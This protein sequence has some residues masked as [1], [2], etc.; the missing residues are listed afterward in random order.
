MKKKL[1]A[2]IITLV[3]LMVQ[4]II[5][6]GL[7]QVY[8]GETSNGPTM[9]SN[10]ATSTGI[11]S[12]YTTDRYIVKYKEN[13]GDK[14]Q[15]GR[16]NLKK[17]LE[18]KIKQSKKV[19]SKKNYD[20]ITLKTK[21]KP[22][23]FINQM[24]KDNED[25]EYIQP[26]YE[27]SLSS[28]DANF[29][30]QWGVNNGQSV[31]DAVYGEKHIDANVVPAWEISR[32]EG[33][34]VAV[35]DTGVDISHEDLSGNVW[36]NAKEIAGNGI[37]DDGNGYIDDVNG[38]N[39]FDDNNKV[40]NQATVNED[41]HGTHVSGIIA[42]VKDN[43]KGIA[44]VAPK[45]KIM[46]LKV[47][48]NGT[49]YTSD[50][51]E[52][53]EYAES[54][55][56]KIV[57]CS[58]GTAKD[59]LALKETIQQSKM[60]FVCA[61]G[62]SAANID[63]SPV[64]PASY[65]LNNVI[66]VASI[67]KS[68]KLT[69]A[70]NY[71][72]SST[73][74]AAPGEDIY[75]TLP[76][77]TYGSRSGTSLAAG[78][79][80]GEAALIVSRYGNLTAQEVKQRI[81]SSSDRL[82][83]LVGKV[84]RGNKINVN[85]AL[86]GLSSEQVMNIGESGGQQ[87]GSQNVDGYSTFYSTPQT[88]SGTIF[89]V[90]AGATNG[91]LNM[92]LSGNTIT[93]LRPFS[94]TTYTAKK[95]DLVSQ[96][97]YSEEFKVESQYSDAVYYYDLS[98]YI[99][100]YLY[101]TG[102]AK[103]VSGE[104]C[105]ALYQDNNQFH[106]ANTGTIII[107]TSSTNYQKFKKKVLIDNSTRYLRISPLSSGTNMEMRVA[108]LGIYDLSSMGMES[109]SEDE[110]EK[111]IRYVS[112]TQAVNTK[113][114]RSV[115]KNLVRNG[116]GEEG[117]SSWINF[118]AVKLSFNSNHFVLESPVACGYVYQK[119][120]VKK[121]TNYCLSAGG[122]TNGLIGIDGYDGYDGDG[123]WMNTQLGF[124][125]TASPS[126]IFN[127][128]DYSTICVFLVSSSTPNITAYF[129]EVMLSEGT[130]VPE[131]YEPYKESSLFIPNKICIN[132][133]GSMTDELN[134]NTGLYIDRIS[135]LINLDGSIAWG[136]NTNFSGY[137]RLF[138]TGLFSYP[139]SSQNIQSN[140]IKYNGQKINQIT[141]WGAI[142]ADTFVAGDGIDV[143]P[144]YIM[145]GNSDSGW[146]DT[147]IPTVEELKAYFYGWKMCA[148]DGSSYVSG[149]KYWKHV[150]DG[151]GITNILPTVSYSGYTPYKLLYKLPNSLT[152]KL[153]IPPITCYSGGTIY[154]D[155]AVKDSAVY[156]NGIIVTNQ[157]LPIK[158]IES[159][160]KIDGSILSP[161]DP[162]KITI[163]P[164]GLT[165]SIASANNGEQYQYT[166]IYDSS[167]S[168]ATTVQFI[169][170]TTSSDQ[171]NDNTNM[172]NELNKKL[173]A[174]TSDVEMLK[175]QIRQQTINAGPFKINCTLDGSFNLVLTASNSKDY[176]KRTFTVIYNPSELDIVDLSAETPTLETGV[177]NISGTNIVITKVALG[178][179]EFFINN[180]INQGSSH[181]GAV[182][183]IIFKSK[184]NGQAT[185]S[186][187]VQ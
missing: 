63:T 111:T 145:V 50:I 136:F 53:I 173:D 187:T 4:Y 7:E 62:N 39:F 120:N 12:G 100:K 45:A 29:T 59:N 84:N 44:G 1:T 108:D 149:T 167:L 55:G 130:T 116:N 128:G 68:G 15:R 71:G 61:V 140:V 142:G 25:I 99:G 85:S 174:L 93:N 102:Y 75:S 121:N 164:N 175:K 27:M 73:S 83:T 146:T 166:Y 23:D 19:R 106:S 159:V 180:P 77:N 143:N 26:D 110:L 16:N 66:S 97:P 178:V 114:I 79:V 46:P 87:N 119:I 153:A 22:D 67:D 184:I 148:S 113:R 141:D 163:S 54:N 21:E 172:I 60:L 123:A 64:Y 35:I 96:S 32:G 30:S 88:G 156:S 40:Y 38:W 117:I 70:S 112:G 135:D 154:I 158:S 109:K 13:N 126:S 10:N 101:I 92:T 182:N 139:G 168:A 179:I 94:G 91:Q 107:S 125:S 161:V 138:V 51:I 49:A 118:S 18:D 127:T 115:G 183:T 86:L 37:D 186:Y 11:S 78:F 147:M 98:N 69:S 165:F 31:S 105:L 41:E 74:V 171:T 33:I 48:K 17:K 122:M 14:G 137:K 36:T 151:T 47:F 42:A 160:Y 152:T 57:N 34:T 150:I 72:E 103:K 20:Q 157:N 181:S 162:S 56:A 52:A 28:N 5:P 76:A 169:V 134:L 155:N 170:P 176:S 3:F 133:I 132:S 82:S 144:L 124:I 89:S 81:M 58:W 43:S 6:S 80:S 129:S 104:A 8:A 131:S 90:P 9:I 24:M 65:G 95:T 185:V 177:C 2:F